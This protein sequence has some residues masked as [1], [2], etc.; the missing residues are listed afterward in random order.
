MTIWPTY[1]LLHLK[2]QVSTVRA[3]DTI[4][5]VNGYI[6]VRDE[7]GISFENQRINLKS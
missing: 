6:V 7:H 1:E 5:S 3:H 4:C 2:S